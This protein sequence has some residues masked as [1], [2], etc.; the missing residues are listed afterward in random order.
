[1]SDFEKDISNPVP[2]EPPMP[3]RGKRPKRPAETGIPVGSVIPFAGKLA[4]ASSP[5][6]PPDP[7]RHIT[8][9]EPMGWMLCDGREFR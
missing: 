4:H 7:Q 2:P 8:D 9:V 3:D 5:A 6:P 1:M